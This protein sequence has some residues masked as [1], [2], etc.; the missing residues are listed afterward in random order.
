MSVKV[1]YVITVLTVLFGCQRRSTE[2][3][4]APNQTVAEKA[5]APLLLFTREQLHSFSH[6]GRKDTF[7]L[8]VLGKDYLRARVRLRIISWAGKLIYDEQFDSNF[9]IDYGILEET[10]DDT[11]ITDSI[12]SAY[13]QKRLAT[14]FD[15]KNF[16]QPAIAAT[17]SYDGYYASERLFKELKK[18]RDA[19]AFY[20]LLGKE[21]GRYIAWSQ[22][23][24]RVMLFY[25]CC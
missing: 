20:Y 23:N 5:N 25:N 9:L 4:K 11:A 21:D 12:R 16:R 17:A 8:E 6:P 3:F 10:E 7:R 14:F 19:I 18:N 24:Q 13:I 1:A 15:E 2:N 22:E